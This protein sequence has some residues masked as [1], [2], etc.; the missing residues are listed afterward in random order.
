MRHGTRWQPEY[1][2]S[3]LCLKE[4]LF[5]HID[6]QHSSF[7]SLCLLNN[8]TD[9]FSLYSS[10]A[11]EEYTVLLPQQ[12]M[13]QTIYPAQKCVVSGMPWFWGILVICLSPKGRKWDKYSSW[14]IYSLLHNI[15]TDKNIFPVIQLLLP[16]LDR[17]ESSRLHTYR[18]V[19]LLVSVLAKCFLS[20]VSLYDSPLVVLKIIFSATV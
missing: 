12:C 13:K 9:F 2:D 1:C 20:L 4:K 11:S 14:K 15:I 6:K 7:K 18:R 16:L 3:N 17:Q 8:T 5:S 19:F 10:R